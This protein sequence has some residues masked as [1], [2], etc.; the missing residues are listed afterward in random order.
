MKFDYDEYN[1]N[2]YKTK[3]KSNGERKEEKY[4]QEKEI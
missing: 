4:N 3:L 2:N 1:N